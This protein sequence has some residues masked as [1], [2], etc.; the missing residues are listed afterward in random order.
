MQEKYTNYFFRYWLEVRILLCKMHVSEALITNLT[1]FRI[2]IFSVLKLHSSC[3][4]FD[5]GW[6]G[7]SIGLDPIKESIL[8]P[9]KGRARPVGADQDRTG[10]RAEV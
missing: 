7:C 6:T 10:T 2:I 5:P 9:G 8:Y 4:K 1:H 3:I